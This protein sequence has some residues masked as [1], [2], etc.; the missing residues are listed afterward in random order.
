MNQNQNVLL[1]QPHSAMVTKL[2]GDFTVPVSYDTAYSYR[3]DEPDPL[4][5]NIPEDIDNLRIEAECYKE[6]W[7]DLDEV[8]TQKF[9]I[10]MGI[11]DKNTVEIEE[12]LKQH[13]IQ[14]PE[15]QNFDVLDK[16]RRICD[17][18]NIQYKY[19]SWSSEY[20]FEAREHF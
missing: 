13:F 12:I 14:S 17:A 19:N 15:F 10:V 5:A 7:Y 20:D 11:N 16:F 1:R 18:N 6:A 3:T 8:N 9:L 4:M 2:P